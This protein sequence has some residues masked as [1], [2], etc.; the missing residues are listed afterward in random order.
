MTTFDTPS[1]IDV[2]V[3][4]GVVG[5]IRVIAS[6]R[7]TTVVN[8]R[9]RKAARSA[10]LRAVE[11]VSVAFADGR[12][13]VSSARN[14]RAYTWFGDGGA[15]EVELQVPTGS[16]LDL[17]S[18]MGEFTCTGEFGASRL[19]SAMG[20]IRI[21]RAESLTVKTSY[22]DVVIDRVDGDLE[23]KTD[24]GE[25]RIRQIGGTGTIRNGNGGTLVEVAGGDLFVKSANGPITVGTASGSVWARTANGSVRVDDVARGEVT[26][27]SSSG[28]LD[29]GVRRG[30]AA[31]LDLK[32][33]YGRVDSTLE[34]SEGPSAEDD[35]VEIRARTSYGSIT[36]RRAS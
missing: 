26:L 1:A 36:V 16:S 4:L 15:I 13:T 32:S 33:G 35:T 14:W 12:L 27:E 9:P 5:D 2:S 24:S 20:A 21:D 28:S 11:L 29:V 25:M 23:A 3:D 22:G 18:A 6:E 34:V 7:A 31:W 10:D 8:I 19:K 17:V 30:T